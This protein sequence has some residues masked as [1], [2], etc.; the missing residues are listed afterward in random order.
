MNKDLQRGIAKE[1][2]EKAAHAKKLE[3]MRNEGTTTGDGDVARNVA[4][5]KKDL[6]A[7]RAVR[8]ALKDK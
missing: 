2:A 4:E 6:K 7:K 5:A 3:E 1:R 8:A